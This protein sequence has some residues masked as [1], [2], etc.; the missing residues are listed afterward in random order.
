MR[1]KLLDFINEKKKYIY[2]HVTDAKLYNRFKY[3]K[4]KT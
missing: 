2:M 1:H 4:N 3:A